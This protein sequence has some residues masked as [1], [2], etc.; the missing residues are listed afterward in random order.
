M[1]DL[2][3]FSLNSNH[4]N[5][6]R[7][8]KTYFPFISIDRTPEEDQLKVY[9]SFHLSF[10]LLNIK[11]FY[12]KESQTRVFP[13]ILVSYYAFS[14]WYLSHIKLEIIVCQCCSETQNKSLSFR[15]VLIFY[16]IFAGN[17]CT[18]L[19]SNLF[20][21]MIFCLMSDSFEK[22]LENSEDQNKI[23]KIVP[24]IVLSQ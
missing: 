4:Q 11:C 17:C 9:W 12:S 8:L 21:L 5:L 23:P 3:F 6:K 22:K 14:L 24:K 15:L 2:I 20:H 16:N 19:Q 18:H 10:L 1:K 13:L 7:I